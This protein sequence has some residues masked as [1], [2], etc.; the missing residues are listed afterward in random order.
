MNDFPT[1]PPT[2]PTPSVPDT[3]GFFSALFDFKFEKYIT[4][5]ALS[6]IYM[7]VTALIALFALGLFFSG[8][9]QGA[10]GILFS[11]FV[12]PL[13]ALVYLIYT[14]L[15][16]EFL[17]NQFRQTELLEQIANK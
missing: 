7:L 8:F 11:L 13:G 1:T 5:K 9:T 3:G 14:R 17:A 10:A 16:L 2:E 4:K 15:I 6:V 12:V